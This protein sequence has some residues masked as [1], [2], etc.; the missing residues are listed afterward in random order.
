M[1]ELTVDMGFVLRTVRDGI[2]KSFSIKEI[3]KLIGDKVNDE[4]RIDGEAFRISSCIETTSAEDAALVY[5]W[6]EI[7]LMVQSEGQTDF[8]LTEIPGDLESVTLKVNSIPY[9]LGADF[10][11][12]DRIIQWKGAFSLDST[13]QIS[14]RYPKE[15]SQIVK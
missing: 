8:L 6:V 4:I 2:S 12:S 7:D 3:L 11:I 5:D 15:I 1:T 9:R 10:D 13:D 14:L